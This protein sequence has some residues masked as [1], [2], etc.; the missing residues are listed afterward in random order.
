MF[1]RLATT[2]LVK[3]RFAKSGF[4]RFWPVQP[5]RAAPVSCQA[6][7]PVHGNDNLPG[8]RHP[9]VSG[10]RRSATPALACH[11]IDRDGRLECR[12]QA[13]PD[14][15]A[16]IGGRDEGRDE[17][18]A[19]GRATGPMQGVTVIHKT[20]FEPSCLERYRRVRRAEPAATVQSIRSTSCVARASLDDAASST[21]AS[22]SFLPLA[23][24]LP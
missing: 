24:D 23:N 6:G 15:D 19:L 9:A 8:F 21:V 17:G 18:S 11:W 7:L 2:G 10:K 12:W 22:R 5:R 14:G 13:E 20:V 1:T 4:A 16:P 3:S